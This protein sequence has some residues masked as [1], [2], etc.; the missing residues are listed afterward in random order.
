MGILKKRIKKKRVESGIVGDRQFELD[1]CLNEAVFN[2]DK[3][4]V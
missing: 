4:G 2:N 1:L 3:G